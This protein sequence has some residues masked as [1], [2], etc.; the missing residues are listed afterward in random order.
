MSLCF[1]GGEIL[2]KE[3]KKLRGLVLEFIFE[4]SLEDQQLI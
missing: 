1:P 3:I 4:F 2:F